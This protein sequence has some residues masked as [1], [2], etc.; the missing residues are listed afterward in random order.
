MQDVGADTKK[1]RPSSRVLQEIIRQVPAEHVTVG[2]LTSTFP[3]HSFG[4]VMLCLGLLAMTPVG[5]TVPGLILVVMAVQLIVGRAEPVFST[6]IRCCGGSAASE[7]RVYLTIET[8]PPGKCSQFLEL[9]GSVAV[10]VPA[11]Y[12]RYMNQ[13]CV[14]MGKVGETVKFGWERHPRRGTVGPRKR[15]RWSTHPDVPSPVHP[16]KMRLPFP[17]P[18]ARHWLCGPLGPSNRRR[19]SRSSRRRSGCRLHFSAARGAMPAATA[20]HKF[21]YTQG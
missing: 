20:G 11:D 13:P 19:R 10:A 1:R 2:W 12:T 7:N 21:R 6:R 4:V 9:I 14:Y 5:S 8:K 15:A 16:W 18:F 3:R 17:N